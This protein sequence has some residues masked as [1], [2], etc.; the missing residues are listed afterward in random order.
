MSWIRNILI[1]ATAWLS[2]TAGAQND[3]CARAERKI[4]SVYA[5]EAG[6]ARDI[7]TY[8]SP[9]Y[10]S[11]FNLAVSGSWTKDFNRWSDR[12]RMRFE[13]AVSYDD[14]LNPAQTA[15]MLGLTAHFGWGLSWKKDFARSWQ[16]TTGPMLDIYG[17]ALYLP[18]NGNNPVSALAS[19]GFDLAASLQWRG[20]IGRVPVIVADEMRIPTLSCFFSPEYGES[21]YEIYLGNRRNLAHFGW[22]GN[23]FGINNLL[24]VKFNFG[25]TGMLVGYRLDLRT[26]RANHLETQL[27]RIAF[28]IGVI[29]NGL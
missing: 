29:P 28:V 17:G 24:S 12:C 18:K 2:L 25:K 9:L 10:Y 15:R 5:F 11:G 13:A 4:T 21:Y 20:H 8:L 3:T 16:V 19:T 26:F 1:F 6:G 14:M 7:S 23:A 22:W 27:L